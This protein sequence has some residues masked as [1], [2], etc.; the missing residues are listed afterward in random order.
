MTGFNITQLRLQNQRLTSPIVTEPTDV[1]HYMGVIQAQD[2]GGAAWAVAQHL[3][4]AT[5]SS[6]VCRPNVS[7][8]GLLCK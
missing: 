3:Q 2:Y 6:V 8:F 4:R 1:V 5:L 7:G